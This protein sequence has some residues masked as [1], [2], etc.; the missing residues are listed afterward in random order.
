MRTIVRACLIVVGVFVLLGA[1]PIQ[2]DYIQYGYACK[3]SSG[4]PG[5]GGKE[6][7]PDS[8]D[9]CCITKATGC[10]NCVPATPTPTPS[11]TP[12]PGGGGRGAWDCAV[13]PSCNPFFYFISVTTDGPDESSGSI[14]P[15]NERVRVEWW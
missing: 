11:P 2:A 4:S 13:D 14:N 8:I 5:P 3:A 9:A 12:T 1:Y 6:C 15:K 7:L 10:D